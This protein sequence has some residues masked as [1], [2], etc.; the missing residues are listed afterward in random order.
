MVSANIATIS[1]FLLSREAGSSI[2]RAK[3]AYLDEHKIK[4]TK[5]RLSEKKYVLIGYRELETL[6][7]TRVLIPKIKYIYYP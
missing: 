3:H 5:N 6:F 4:R 7:S 1:T 2:A